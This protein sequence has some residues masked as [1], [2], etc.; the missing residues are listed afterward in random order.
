MRAFGGSF[1]EQY[2]K[3]PSFYQW[4]MRRTYFQADMCLLESHRM[5]NFFAS[6]GA[7]RPEWFS[8]Y[9]RDAGLNQTTPYKSKCEKIVFLG[10][11]VK[12]KGIDTILDAA[13]EL[14]SEVT[15]D[16]YGPLSRDYTPEKINTLGGDRVT[17]RGLLSPEEIVE[18]LWDYDALVLPT[19]WPGEGY[20]AVVL[21]AYAHGIPVITTCWLVLEEIVDETSGILIEPQKPDQLSDAINRLHNNEQ[22]YQ[23]LQLGARSKAGHF[24][25]STWA[26]KFEQ[27]CYKV[28]Q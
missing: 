2:Q 16:I 12:E 7:H 22:L 21:E 13:S 17:Y 28:S 3:L 14:E 1:D 15:I 25:V 8:N 18:K 23:T 4:W 20:P 27:F 6:I 11:V 24:S 19:Y 26:E 10:R 9:T 5:V